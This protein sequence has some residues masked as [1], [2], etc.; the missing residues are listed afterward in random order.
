MVRVAGKCVSDPFNRG[1]HI[2]TSR[3]KQR[4]QRCLCYHLLRI[5]GVFRQSNYIAV[6]SADANLSGRKIDC[7]INLTV[8]TAQ[9]QHQHIV[10]VNPYVVVPGKL[11]Y[12]IICGMISAGINFSADRL[13]EIYLHRHAE[14]V[15][16][17][18]TAVCIAGTRNITG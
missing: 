9:V 17:V 11:K 2:S 13:T 1:R 12:H 4:F 3:F 14:M 5:C 16:D 6:S 10:N 7:A 18:L 15:V 8:Y